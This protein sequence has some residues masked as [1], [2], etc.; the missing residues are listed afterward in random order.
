MTY[1]ER[2]SFFGI[3][4]LSDRRDVAELVYLHKLIRGDLDSADIQLLRFHA[5]N[6]LRCTDLF[7]LKIHNTNIGFFRPI[8]R[9]MRSYNSMARALPDLDI[10]SGTTRVFRSA[11]RAGIVS[12]SVT[13]GIT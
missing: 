10:F 8:D 6:R 1:R 2:L 7:R 3:D 5:N 9:M 12:R 13:D 11:I 4:R